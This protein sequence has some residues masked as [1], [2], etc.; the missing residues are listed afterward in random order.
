MQ[1][2]IKKI[3]SNDALQHLIGERE[4]AYYLSQ[5][6]STFLS[7]KNE[8]EVLRILFLLINAIF[9][10][11]FSDEEERILLDKTYKLLKTVNIKEEEPRQIFMS[12]IGIDGIHPEILYFF[13]LAVISLKNDRT[14]SI[15][16]DLRDFSIPANDNNNNWKFRL[17]NKSLS[18]FILLIRKLNGFQ[19]ISEALHIIDNL[20][21]EQSDFEGGY[22]K[23]FTYREEVI[24]A[25]QLLGIYHLSKAIVETANY[26]ID[27]YK[28][29]ERLDAVIRQ[30][31]DTSLKLFASEPRMES[32]ITLVNYGL[33]TLYKNSIWNRTKFNDKIQALC[34]KKAEYGAIELLP[35]QRDALSQN[36]LDVASNVTVLQ[37]PTSA[38]KTLLAEFNILVTKSLRPDAKIIYVVPSRA[39]VNQVYFDLKSDLESLNFVI[40]KT[41]SAIEIDPTEN[42][43]LTSD[44]EIDILVST[45]EK[46]DLLIRRNHPAVEDVSMF[47]IDEAHTIQ[48]GERGAR[49]ELLL[50]ILRRERPNAK[51]MLLSP[52]IKNAG[53]TLTDWLGGG[54]SVSI[55]W[56]P[57]EKLLIGLNYRKTKK[58]D[59]IQF[60][61]IPS[62]YSAL[63]HL[64]SGS[65]DNPYTLNSTGIKS[66]ILEIA[67]KHFAES[68]K[69]M[70]ILCGG[71]KSVENKANFIYDNINT[72]SNTD[73]INLIR[74]FIDDEVGKPTLLTKVLVKG[75]ATHHAGLSDETKLLVEHLI[76]EGHINYVC[77]TTTIAEGVNF[78]VSSVFFDDY[79]KGN[80]GNLSSNDFWNIAG[81]AGRTLVDNF[82]KIILPFHSKESKET[83]QK[84]IVKV[85]MN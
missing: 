5:I 23:Q 46:L 51:F 63:S 22:L 31:I 18:A 79:R 40:E 12:T 43:F 11:D 13:Y 38:G 1:E 85:Q 62:P 59:E 61:I 70:L 74:K 53:E 45:P 68:E 81:R 48:N 4:K 24:Q 65:F 47:I 34:R 66:Q 3:L 32:L 49:L 60:S 72:I 56:K 8:E 75:I 44:S 27:G 17:I 77:A 6:D 71:P 15:R 58:V 25:Y 82:G 42:A 76:R 83:A 29:K 50:A 37:M 41:S 28:Y 36:L 55:D 35:S 52:F 78:P 2:L 30:H 57:A 20:K 19:D 80:K 21:K 10:A 14:I 33:K 84:I 64:Q 7:N 9:S 16:I 54:N 69:T 73:E 39:L 67:T 26:L